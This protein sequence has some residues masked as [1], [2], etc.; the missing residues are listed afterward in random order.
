MLAFRGPRFH[1]CFCESAEP[2]ARVLHATLVWKQRRTMDDLP[3]LLHSESL[4]RI[5]PRARMPCSSL[6]SRPQARYPE[7]SQ[8]NSLPQSFQEPVQKPAIVL[9]ALLLFTQYMRFVDC[10]AYVAVD[11]SANQ[12]RCLPLKSAIP[13]F[14][15]PSF[16]VL[17]RHVTASQ[18]SAKQVECSAMLIPCTTYALKLTDGPSAAACLI[19]KDVED[20][21][22]VVA[23][24]GLGQGVSF[25]S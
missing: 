24:R 14:A 1:H 18:L 25:A 15:C 21:R 22:R 6:V 16:P 10:S 20:G 9:E 2:R 3:C 13:F 7:V 8:A 11:Q 4:Q 5:L 23:L 12:R 17:L 19:W